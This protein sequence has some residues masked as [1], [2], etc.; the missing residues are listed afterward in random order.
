MAYTTEALVEAELQ[1]QFDVNSTPSSAQITN[2]IA[3]AESEINSVLKRTFTTTTA[4]NE[5]YDMPH[6]Q[7]FLILKNK[8]VIAISSLS[9]NDAGLGSTPNWVTL[10]EGHAFDYLLYKSTGRIKFHSLTYRIPSGS[11]IIKTTYTYG[12]LEG[13]TVPKVI[14]ELATLIVKER[15]LETFMNK[16]RKKSP[17]DMNIGELSIKHSFAS[18]SGQKKEFW[19]KVDRIY[20]SKGKFKSYTYH[21]N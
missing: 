8:P 9:Y 6:N 16:L 21:E 14:Q 3:E 4:T 15:V 13:G 19:N 5:Y 7:D 20:G 18:V 11:Q 2:W 17:V 12:D 1:M 10:T